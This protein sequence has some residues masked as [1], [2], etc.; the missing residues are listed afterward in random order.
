MRDPYESKALGVIAVLVVVVPLALLAAG[1]VA[2][3]A[4]V[5]MYAGVSWW[6]ALLVGLWVFVVLPAAMI[7]IGRWLYRLRTEAKS[8]IRERRQT[9]V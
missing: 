3:R 9:G 6:Q 7:L 5:L 1:L 4:G 2:L 8:D